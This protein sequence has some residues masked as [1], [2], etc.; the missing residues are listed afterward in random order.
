M[1][2]RD[3]LQTNEMNRILT[4]SQKSRASI[5]RVRRTGVVAEPSAAEVHADAGCICPILTDASSAID[6]PFVIF[7]DK[8]DGKAYAYSLGC[9]SPTS[10]IIVAEPSPAAMLPMLSGDAISFN[11]SQFIDPPIHH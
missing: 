2:A 4:P 11:F 7:F 8:M 5:D 6:R 1:D 3:F 9:L 10:F